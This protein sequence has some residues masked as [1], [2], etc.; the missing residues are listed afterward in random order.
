LLPEKW[1]YSLPMDKIF[2]SCNPSSSSVL[3]LGRD[4]TLRYF[5][6]GTDG[7][8]KEAW[9]AVSG[10]YDEGECSD[11]KCVENG[12]TFVKDEYKWYVVMGQTR[13]E[14]T[15]DVERDFCTK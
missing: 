5:T 1:L 12:V 9:N 8:R 4:G 7:Q 2:P 14:L 10:V 3:E 13:N 15:R 11:G 6:R